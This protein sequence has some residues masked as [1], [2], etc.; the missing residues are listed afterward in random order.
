MA[1]TASKATTPAHTAPSHT[2][3]EDSSH[4]DPDTGEVLP[5]PTVSTGAT[6]NGMVAFS[7]TIPQL[8]VVKRVTL[9]VLPFPAGH[10]IVAKLVDRIKTGKV[11]EN[12]KIKQAAKVVTIEAQSGDQRTLI[13][14][15]VLENELDQAYPDGEYVG[16]WFRITK[17]APKEGKRY[18]NFV[19]EEVEIA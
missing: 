7:A 3:A 10:T 2:P 15:H 19:I 1:K 13:V 11:I 8:K 6:E 9:P 17:L 5:A 16:H 18:P 12:S 14:N 4:Y